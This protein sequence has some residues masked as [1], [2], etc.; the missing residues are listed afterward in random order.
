LKEKFL[1]TTRKKWEGAPGYGVSAGSQHSYEEE[2]CQ[3]PRTHADWLWDWVPP[4]DW[5][6]ELW[7]DLRNPKEA[8]L[9][10]SR[11]IVFHTSLTFRIWLHWIVFSICI[12]PNPEVLSVVEIL[13]LSETRHSSLS[14]QFLDSIWC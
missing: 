4:G 13:S 12:P 7:H 2:V 11:T 1:E 5:L 9:A 14:V 10:A 6:P 3:S 8:V